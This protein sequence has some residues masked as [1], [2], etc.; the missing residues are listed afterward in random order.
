MSRVG[1]GGETLQS[2]LAR[3]FEDD[4]DEIHVVKKV[5][6]DDSA[7]GAGIREKKWRADLE[8]VIG[9]EKVWTS[10]LNARRQSA[11]ESALRTVPRGM[12]EKFPL[13]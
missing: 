10:L 8:T 3:A 5:L 12:K 1:E 2:F 11:I 4:E 13:L 6:L 9:N 7:N